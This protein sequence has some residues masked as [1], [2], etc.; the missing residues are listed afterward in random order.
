MST[1]PTTSIISSNL[2]G[3]VAVFMSDATPTKSPHEWMVAFAPDGTR[4][5]PR[6]SSTP[7]FTQSGA[8]F[9]PW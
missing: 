9:V 5:V 7:T 6:P 1:S 4:N 2:L 8:S 3:R